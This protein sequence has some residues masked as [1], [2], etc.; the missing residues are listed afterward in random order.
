M[1]LYWEFFYFWG[2]ALGCADFSLLSTGT[3]EMPRAIKR[4]NVSNGLATFMHGNKSVRQ[5]SATNFK[6]A[7][8]PASV[9]PTNNKKKKKRHMEAKVEAR[10]KIKFFVRVMQVDSYLL[11]SSKPEARLEFKQTVR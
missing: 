10:W 11:T 9:Q 1:V 5:R 4:N 2:G 3:R 7:R 8:G 6:K